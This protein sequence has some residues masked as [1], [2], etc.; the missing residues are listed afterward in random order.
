M[1]AKKEPYTM[2][3][4]RLIGFEASARSTHYGVV[5]PIYQED[6]AGYYNGVYRSEVRVNKEYR[7]QIEDSVAMALAGLHNY[8]IG[9]LYMK[10]RELEAADLKR[11]K[12]L[13]KEKAALKAENIAKKAKQGLL[14]KAKS[15]EPQRV[16]ECG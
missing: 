10:E 4:R 8:F 5:V 15:G 3:N 9:Q 1:T 12:K 16:I 7:L 13:A 6:W 11:K 14:K 2:H